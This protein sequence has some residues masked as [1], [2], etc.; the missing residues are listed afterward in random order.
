M[1]SQGAD[2]VE[3]ILESENDVYLPWPVLLEI[4]YTTIRKKGEKE[5]ERRFALTKQLPVKIIWAVDEANVLIAARYK[6][7]YRLSFADSLIAAIAFQKKAILIHKDP[8]F[9]ALL[10]QLEMEAL[11]YKT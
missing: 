1:E 4:Y 5:A 8:E 6:S 11:P 10:G 3:K 2:L 7:K 9:E